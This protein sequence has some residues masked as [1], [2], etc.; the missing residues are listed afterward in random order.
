[1]GVVDTLG[2]GQTALLNWFMSL[3]QSDQM[4]HTLDFCLNQPGIKCEKSKELTVLIYNVPP[5]VS[6]VKE[7]GD[8]QPASQPLATL[9]PTQSREDL[10][11]I[12]SGNRDE[13][14]IR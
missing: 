5:F 8:I 1:M 14:P 4:L 10:C 3:L 2:Q 12:R 13:F 7:G 6:G 11:K 9:L